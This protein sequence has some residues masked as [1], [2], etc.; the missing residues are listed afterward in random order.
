MPDRTVIAVQVDDE[1]GVASGIVD[2]E[3]G[4]TQL[5]DDEVGDRL[6]D[7]VVQVGG[8][9]LRRPVRPY[10]QIAGRIR[11]DPAM[12]TISSASRATPM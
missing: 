11:T 4:R 10:R 9:R 12:P 3:P 2:V 5:A 1:V 8:Q 7:R 6:S